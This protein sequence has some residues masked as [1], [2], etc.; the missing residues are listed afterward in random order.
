MKQSGMLIKNDFAVC[1]TAA[2]VPVAPEQMEVFGGDA[3]RF[4]HFQE[5]NATMRHTQNLS[6]RT[7][8]L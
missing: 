5:S 4:D 8:W 6:I 1:M 7:V 2:C 3:W